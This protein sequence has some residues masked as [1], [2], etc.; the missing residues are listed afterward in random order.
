[1]NKDL[2]IFS[3]YVGAS[4]EDILTMMRAMKALRESGSHCL[5]ICLIDGFDDDPRDL[6]DIPEARAFCRRLVSLG[7][8]SWLEFALCDPQTDIDKVAKDGLGALE[9][10]M[11]AEGKMHKRTPLTLELVEGAKRAVMK[12]NR[13]SDRAIGKYKPR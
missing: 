13:A 8:I 7:F 3:P 12:S 9:I 1:M 4:N 5:V 11:I 10:W 2:A 6:W